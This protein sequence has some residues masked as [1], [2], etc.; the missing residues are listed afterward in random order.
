M[1]KKYELLYEE[2]REKIRS[3]A[4]PPRTKLPSKRVM[5]NRTGY[6]V[7]T[8]EHAFAILADEGY[9][10]PREKSGYY[11]ANLDFSAGGGL[12]EERKLHTDAVRHLPEPKNPGDPDFEYSVWFSTVRRVISEY[13]N[14]LFF[15]A[16]N[17]GCEILRNAIADYLDRYRGMRAD[18]GAIVIGSGAE[19][20]YETAVKILGFGT[21][22]AIEDPCYR[23]IGAA[24][25]S[26]GITPEKL[27]IGDDGIPGE[28]LLH[29]GADLLHVTPFHSVPSG[30]SVSLAKKLEYLA[31]ARRE[32]KWILED[33]FDS[34]F[35]APGQPVRTLF[36]LDD[37]GSVIY[38][39]TFSKSISPSV[40]IGY[41]ILPERLLSSYRERVGMLS[42]SVP[43]MDQYILAEFIAS[44]SFE[45]H[46]NRT[47]RRLAARKDGKT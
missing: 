32:G 31:F 46:L 15:R 28:L 39:N 30:V 18:P 19:Q 38:V 22:I 3:G 23:Q 9:L 1:K 44:G 24:Y 21:K 8:V 42:C 40:R 4:Y 16:P 17:Q 6:S 43:V 20:L 2:V 34:E 36:S 13:G 7:I 25:A 26:L 12:T 47:R 5:S 41:M 27:K 35:F 33:D 29:T 37:S 45:R 10:V 14:R 11:V